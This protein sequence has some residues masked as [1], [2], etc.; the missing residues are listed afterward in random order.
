ML[1]NKNKVLVL[2]MLLVPC[3]M[4]GMDSGTAYR[5]VRPESREAIDAIKREHAS[6]RVHTLYDAPP[7]ASVKSFSGSGHVSGYSEPT[8]QMTQREFE[9][10]LVKAVARELAKQTKANE[11][12]AKE[13]GIS[14]NDIKNKNAFEGRKTERFELSKQI[15]ALKTSKD[16]VEF[17][18]KHENL[19]TKGE[20]K[21][22]K[23]L[24]KRLKQAEK[25]QNVITKR[26]SKEDKRTYLQLKKEQKRK[27]K[28][29]WYKRIGAGVGSVLALV[30]KIKRN[31]R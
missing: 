23:K 12:F 19:L 20:S 29:R 3:G 27:K 31:K 30:A 10:H 8:Y 9:A 17:R 18:K 4:F 25:K 16:A 26:V 24:A 1:L 2:S 21:R 28:K 5:D 13:F 14:D 22:L 7:T 11:D 6:G 15:A